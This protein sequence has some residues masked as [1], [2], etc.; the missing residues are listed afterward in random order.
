MKCMSVGLIASIASA[1]PIIV[2][3]RLAGQPVAVTVS[4]QPQ[5]DPAFNANSPIEFD[6]PPTFNGVLS[7]RIYD[8]T[9]DGNGQP[10]QDIGA[11]TINGGQ[12]GT[13]SRM[14]LF[15]S[16]ES[17]FPLLSG[18]RIETRGVRSFGTPTSSGLSITNPDLRRQTR[19]AI[20]TVTDIKG[21]ITAG[22]I[23]RIQAGIANELGNPLFSGD[24]SA[25]ITAI[26][27][28]REWINGA[29]TLKAIEEVNIVGLLSG[30]LH[31]VDFA[32]YTPG[33]ETSYA[34]IGRV[35]V[36]GTAQYRAWDLIGE[37]FRQTAVVGDI[38]AETGRITEVYTVGSIG[39]VVENCP[40]PQCFAG[41]QPTILAADGIDRRV[42]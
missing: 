40:P 2:E 1:Q 23:F 4:G 10:D 12:P 22:Q 33:Q 13:T 16:G 34:N 31:A 39:A 8:S 3:V 41:F 20:A 14:D 18:T 11:V 9:L 25:N 7:V 36:R 38:V 6:L 32:G 27:R 19:V 28:D 42:A 37:F 17:S 29:G 30:N 35:I 15:L 5:V 24:V 21:N 26:N